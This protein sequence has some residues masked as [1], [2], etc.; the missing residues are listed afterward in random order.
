MYL[1]PLHW[2][3]K[4]ERESWGIDVA[5]SFRR[6][7]RTHEVTLLSADQ[8]AASFALCEG[9]WVSLKRTLTDNEPSVLALCFR[10]NRLYCFDCRTTNETAEGVNIPEIVAEWA[11]DLENSVLGQLDQ[12][13]A[14]AQHGLAWLL[15]ADS[16]STLYRGLI[17]QP[18]GQDPASGPCP[19]VH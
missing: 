4:F 15:T 10:E 6:R 18:D 5:L 7:K 9:C 17:R 1:E 8:S 3:L 13:E 16:A 19:T 12:G 2:N 14:Q 11:I